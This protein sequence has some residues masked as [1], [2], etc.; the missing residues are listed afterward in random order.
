MSAHTPE[1]IA[2]FCERLRHYAA[3]AS[4]ISRQSIDM[5]AAADLISAQF[6]TRDYLIRNVLQPAFPGITPLPTL[7]GVCTQVDHVLAGQQEAI[8]EAYALL[9]TV[10]TDDKRIHLAR[11]TLLSAM[12]G[13][14]STRQ[15][16][17]LEKFAATRERDL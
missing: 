7:D 2:E 10:V 5:D 1:Q 6:A 14:G 9:W 12:G 17:A 16:L 11:R 13:Q 4:V 8:A 15:K 3:S